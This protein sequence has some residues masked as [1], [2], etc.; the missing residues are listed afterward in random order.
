MK[1]THFFLSST[2]RLSNMLEYFVTSLMV[3]H[4]FVVLL[5]AALLFSTIPTQCCKRKK[6]SSSSKKHKKKHRKG[7]KKSKQTT[8]P[9]TTP[10]ATPILPTPLTP[11]PITPMTPVMQQT[12][13][14]APTP[15][16]GSQESGESLHNKPTAP[17]VVI[18]VTSTKSKE[19][20][21]KEDEK[22]SKKSEKEQEDSGELL[23]CRDYIPENFAEL[24]WLF[25]L[26]D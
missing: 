16:G 8:N 25:D 4:L 26:L 23:R 21:D 17:P 24:K 11:T 10:T 9:T 7:K 22:K 14:V 20:V 6:P 1:P 13:K 2:S 19:N 12:P 3:Y 5:P 18:P 15:I